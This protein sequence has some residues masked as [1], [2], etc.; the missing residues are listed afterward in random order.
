MIAE[1]F[2]LKGWK[3][4]VRSLH[5]VRLLREILICRQGRIGGEASI[6]SAGQSLHHNDSCIELVPSRRCSCRHG[7][8]TVAFRASPVYA[9]IAHFKR[10]PALFFLTEIKSKLSESRRDF[11]CSRYEQIWFHFVKSILITLLRSHDYWIEHNFV[12]VVGP[13]PIKSLRLALIAG[14]EEKALTIYTSGTVVHF[15]TST[16][17]FR[18]EYLHFF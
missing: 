18:M 13:S 8:V 12:Y 3:T 2:S 17:F 10:F 5:H 7:C 6:V 15:A 9:I 14:D 16:N 11:Y 4:V 1:W